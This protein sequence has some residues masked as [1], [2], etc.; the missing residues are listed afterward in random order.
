MTI[1]ITGGNGTVSSALLTALELESQDVRALVRDP[2]KAPENVQV[3]VADLNDRAT[4][5]PP[6]KG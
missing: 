2:A 5:S 1:L 4:L 6:S 3:T